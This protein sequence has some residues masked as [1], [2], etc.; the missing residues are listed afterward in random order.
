MPHPSGG[1]RQ[2]SKQ[3]TGKVT[4]GSFSIYAD[5]YRWFGLKNRTTA[6]DLLSHLQGH[7][8]HNLPSEGWH[9]PTRPAGSRRT[10]CGP[11]VA[12][13]NQAV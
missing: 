7:R 3:K 6:D 12:A 10:Q 5:K 4:Y 13:Y 1:R 2:H 11:R 9:N 8:H